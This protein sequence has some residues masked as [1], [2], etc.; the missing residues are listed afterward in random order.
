M[1]PFSIVYL[2]YNIFQAGTDCNTQIAVQHY[3]HGFFQVWEQN[4]R[5]DLEQG[6]RG[7]R[8]SHF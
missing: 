4:I 5:P 6:Q 3:S 2:P 8:H 1:A 7:L